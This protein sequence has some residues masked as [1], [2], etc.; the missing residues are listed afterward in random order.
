MSWD[1][2]NRATPPT[3]KGALKAI[4]CGLLLALV[5]IVLPLALW[6]AGVF[7][8]GIH[9][10][11]EAIKQKNNAGNWTSAQAQFERDFADFQ[12]FQVQ[13]TG[14]QTALDQFNRDHPANPNAMPGD[15][16]EEK[17]NQL[18]DDLSGVVQQCG[19]TAADYNTA[20]RSYLS[21]QFRAADLPPSLD[22]ADCTP[23]Q[24][25]RPTP[26]HS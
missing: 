15:P 21:E 24:T 23:V 18:S 22:P 4:G 12:K 26:T 13:A 7:T 19:N 17:R 25:S 20:A 5:V 10:K 8:S 11:G 1:D 2:F 9:G 16:N 3:G 6:A 14:A